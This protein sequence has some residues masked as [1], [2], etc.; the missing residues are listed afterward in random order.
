ML[1]NRS[2]GGLRRSLVLWVLERR[3]SGQL[4]PVNRWS[5]RMPIDNPVPIRRRPPDAGEALDVMI[6]ATCPNT[7]DG[8]VRLKWQTMRIVTLERE[9][10]V[11]RG[12]PGEVV[13]LEF[14]I[15]KKKMYPKGE[16]VI[17]ANPDVKKTIVSPFEI[18][19]KCPHYDSCGGCDFL[20]M[21]YG[22]QLVEKERWVQQALTKA[23]VSLST[24]RRIRP[25]QPQERFAHRTE[26]RFSE[27]EGDLF[28]GPA[29]DGPG[30]LE[31][32]PPYGC[33]LP[34]RSVTRLLASVFTVFRERW[35]ATKP[36]FS[37][38]EEKYG[39]GTF[40][41]MLVLCTRPPSKPE[42]VRRGPR[43]E[44]LLNIV[45][46]HP[47][48]DCKERLGPLVRAAASSL[49]QRLVGVVANVQRSKRGLMGGRQEVLL[50]GRRHVRH[51]LE[52][53]IRGQMQQFVLELGACSRLPA[54]TRAL[55]EII[56]T[57]LDA[58]ELHETDVVWHCFCGG[59]EVSLALGAACKHV[60]AVGTSH[61]EVS[62]LKRNLAANE[63]TNT[64]A[65]LAN[66]R[67][68]W[69]LRQLSHH[70]TQ[71][72]QRRLLLGSGEEQEKARDYAV[73]AFV[74]GESRRRQY[75]RL[76]AAP[77]NAP[78]LK[79]DALAHQELRTLLPAFVRDFRP[80]TTTLPALRPSRGDDD[81]VKSRE[82]PVE[83]ESKLKGLY[84]RL[85]MKYHPDKNPDDPEASE[86]FQALLRAYK[87][88]VGDS[89]GPEEGDDEA[90]DPF[91]VAM[92]SNYR[93]K[94]K[95]R[96]REDTNDTGKRSLRSA[97]P[98]DDSTAEGGEDPWADGE[99]EGGAD[100]DEEL[101]PIVPFLEIDDAWGEGAKEP[102]RKEHGPRDRT[103]KK[104]GESM[105]R[106]IVVGDGPVDLTVAEGAALP[107]A[108]LAPP[109][110][111]VVSQPR[112]RKAGQGT[113]RH[114]HSWLRSTAARSIIY[115]ASDAAAFQADLKQLMELGY[116]L[117]LVQPFD[118]EPHRRP[119]LLVAKLDLIR[120]LA[121][122]NEYTKQSDY[123]LAGTLAALPGDHPQP[124]LGSG[125]Y[126]STSRSSGLV[127]DLSRKQ[128]TRVQDRSPHTPT[129]LP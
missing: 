1:T 104:P 37:I 77:F 65:V 78:L 53:Q 29:G 68:P 21:R 2:S 61:P 105:S 110:V 35:A 9:W 23:G 127:R 13:R 117:K 99:G 55:P 27:V 67:S 51:A 47:V 83:M 34:P 102:T 87:A 54:H 57:V 32:D 42:G 74:P 93:K 20:N 25:S 116:G 92:A 109:D 3:V 79:E 8:I 66:L 28:F 63:T 125:G 71:S 124:L 70:I 90:T 12:L 112:P 41:S 101:D 62:E 120:P 59:G 60:V 115:V 44:V 49:N 18:A 31:D 91:L 113:P 16:Y 7:G 122:S 40:K 30:E 94:F 98:Q 52:V 36:L 58:C 15:V 46:A 129:M 88:L 103:S 6:I 108:T 89:A 73:A 4:V 80:S 81:A 69:V 17:L 106:E 118:P 111:I 45:L 72:Q 96:W 84:R 126:T 75:Q 82:V 10:I 86:R 64:T 128:D 5:T 95:H 14:G 121:G 38:Y 43:T 114:F 50:Y 19:S 123:L 56:E 24:L 100:D 48:D 39:F 119:L 11:R 97:A 33:V 85:A 22:R 76:S 107:S 26:W